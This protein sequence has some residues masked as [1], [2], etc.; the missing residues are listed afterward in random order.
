MVAG[1]FISGLNFDRSP[2]T[3]SLAEDQRAT[4]ETALAGFGMTAQQAETYRPWVVTLL[5]ESSEIADADLAV[6][7]G[8][9]ATLQRGLP[10][11]RV[12]YLETANQQMRL[13]SSGTEAE[14]V[15]TLAARL[16][17]K[18]DSS[19]GLTDALVAAW[20]AGD[21]TAL[22]GLFDADAASGDQQLLDRLLYQRNRNWLV[23]LERMLADN[24][25]NLIVVGAAHLLGDKGVVAL[26][27][28]A[29]YMVRRL[30]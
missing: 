28:D 14:Q 23:P 17:Q 25:A 9:E 5:L 13:F 18:D 4:L 20:A 15:A 29:G 30:Q 12:A 21:Q 19:P 3:Q 24:E 16:N 6:A 26:L 27:N 7:S 2:W 8:V 10:R 11:G 1:L 22:L